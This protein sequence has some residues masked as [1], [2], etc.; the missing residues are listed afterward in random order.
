MEGFGNVGLLEEK[1]VPHIFDTIARNTSLESLL[2]L[3]GPG[4]S[5]GS[6]I[7]LE[8]P[9]LQWTFPSEVVI[10]GLVLTTHKEHALKSLRLRTNTDLA[11][12]YDF[13]SQPQPLHLNQDVSK[14]CMLGTFFQTKNR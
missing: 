3:S 10:N 4:I 14:P 7:G 8:R 2:P 12:P 11:N 6:R 13:E 5:F 1:G 9:S